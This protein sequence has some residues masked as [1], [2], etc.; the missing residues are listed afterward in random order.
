MTSIKGLTLARSWTGKCAYVISEPKRKRE[1]RTEYSPLRN[2]VNS[3]NP[4]AKTSKH[5]AMQTIAGCK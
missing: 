5:L 4:G 1:F 3:Q 2:H